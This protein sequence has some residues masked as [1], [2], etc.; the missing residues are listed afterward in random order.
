VTQTR[1]LPKGPCATRRARGTEGRASS[2]TSRPAPNGSGSSSGARPRRRRGT[3]V[4]FSEADPGSRSPRLCSVATPGVYFREDDFSEV[5]TTTTALPIREQQRPTRLGRLLLAFSSGGQLDVRAHFRFRLS[6]AGQLSRSHKRRNRQ[7]GSGAI[8][9]TP[10]I[11]RRSPGIRA[12]QVRHHR[13]SGYRGA[14]KAGTVAAARVGGA[15][16][17]GRRFRR[18]RSL[19]ANGARTRAPSEWGR[20]A[21]RLLSVARAGP[22]DRAGSGAVGQ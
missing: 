8:R 10:S 1:A 7:A 11:A 12:E 14:T 4:V 6:A 22:Q 5:R 20:P 17:A 19:A 13:P 2:D 3:A 16:H 9:P 18:G 15:S 21:S